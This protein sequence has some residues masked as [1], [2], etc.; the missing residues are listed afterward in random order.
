[1]YTAENLST[2]Q[3]HL[4]DYCVYIFSSDAALI[5]FVS[6]VNFHLDDECFHRLNYL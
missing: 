6:A 3:S 5:N 2:R 4:L 1:M